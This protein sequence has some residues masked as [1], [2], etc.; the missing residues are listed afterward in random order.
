M[1][2]KPDRLHQI[3][4]SYNAGEDRLLMRASTQQ[5][6]EY[7]IWLTR[8][9]TGLLANILMQAMD[10]FGGA[11]ALGANPATRSMFK[12]GAMDKAF[13]TDKATEFPLGK[14]GFLA[15]AIKTAD[16]PEGNL[17]LE[18][19]PKKG[20]GVSL[21]LDK[22]LLYLFHNLLSQGIARAEWHLGQGQ[23]AQSARVH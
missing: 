14:N 7:R 18:L 16:T 8:R 17:H 21:N 4:V 23:E 20:Q 5:G 10:K 15:W 6:D 3:N 12:A 2:Q 13:D 22:P 11:A 9:F 1:K 19:L